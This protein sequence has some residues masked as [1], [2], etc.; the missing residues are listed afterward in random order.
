MQTASDA[1]TSPLIR[2]F[3]A[4]S[5]AYDQESVDGILTAIRSR[6]PE[7]PGTVMIAGGSSVGAS[8]PPTEKGRAA[9][10]ELRAHGWK[11]ATN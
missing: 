9:A 4:N 10:R 2:S 11:I 1:P 7:R 6:M 5:N 8:A 3:L